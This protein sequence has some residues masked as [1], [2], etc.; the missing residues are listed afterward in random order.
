MSKKEKKIKKAK[1]K[2]LKDKRAFRLPYGVIGKILLGTAAVAGFVLVSAAAPNVWSALRMFEKK[3]R[4]SFK[5]YQQ[6]E[7]IRKEAAKLAKKKLI[8]VFEKK[9]ELCMRLTEKGRQ[10]L[11]RYK[12]KEKSLEKKSWDRKWRLIIFDIEEKKR[13]L[14]DAIR[15]QMYS[16]GFVKLQDSVWTYPHEC[17]QVVALLKAQYHIGKELLYI[18]A[19][20]IEEDEQL[21]EKFNLK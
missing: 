10:E 21:K 13:G 3:H 1:E 20:D 8:V 18:V 11:I 7:I 9:G 16:F 15:Q 5:R 19:G 2:R 6:P 12:F 17:E 14:R 4:R